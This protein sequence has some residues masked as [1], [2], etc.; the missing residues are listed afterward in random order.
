MGDKV[1]EGL[2]QFLRLGRDLRLAGL[3]GGVALGSGR[4]CWVVSWAC[5][6]YVGEESV[7]PVNGLAW[8]GLFF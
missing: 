8:R 5:I 7:A 6:A 1:E 4:R 2:L 3:D